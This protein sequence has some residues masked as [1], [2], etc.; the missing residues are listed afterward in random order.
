MKLNVHIFFCTLCVLLNFGPVPPSF[1][2]APVELRWLQE[3]RPDNPVGISWGVP[4]P[5]GKVQKG[6]HFILETKNGT[7]LPLQNWPLAYWPDGSLKWSGFATVAPVNNSLL[8]LKISEKSTAFENEVHLIENTRK[9][10]ISTGTLDCIIPK[11]GT[12]LLDSLRI[13]GR[14]IAGKGSI[15]CIVQD[16]LDEN[17][18]TLQRKLYNSI[19]N[20]VTVEQK[21]PV[22][23]MVRIRGRLKSEA[24]DHSWLPLDIRMYFYA[25]SNAVRL[26]NTM[27]YDGDEH[28][29]FI[30][31]L[32]WTFSIPMREQLH[33]RHVRFA[34]ENR[35]MWAEP[36]RPLTGRRVISIDDK[37]VFPDQVKGKAI[38]NTKQFT[39]DKQALIKDLPAW[40]DYRLIQNTANGFLVQKRT[41][42]QSAWITAHAGKRSA[43]YA[44]AGDTGGGLGIGIKDFWQ[45]YP[46]AME[47][48]H[49]TSDHAHLKAWLW[50]P[51]AEAMDMRHYDTIPHGLEAT[52][53]DVQKGL[54][55][56][57]GIARTSELTLFAHSETPPTETLSRQAEIG[58][59][60]PLLTISPEYLHSTGVFGIWS[61]PDRSSPGKAWIEN[62]LNQAIRFYQKEIDQRNWYGFWDYGDVMHSYDPVRHTWR[63]DIGGF[64]WD[65]TELASEFWLWYNYIRTGRKDIFRMAE[66]MTRHTSEVDV[67]HIGKLAGLGSRHNV[68]HWG[69]GSKEVR[70]SQA[71][72]RR[73][74]YYL[75]TDERTGDI[76]QEVAEK[77]DRAMTELDPLRLIYPKTEYPTHARIGPDWLA[78]AG[79]WMTAWERT[80]DNKW[81]N[82]ITSGI[83]SLAKMPYGFFSGELGA[84]GY[85]PATNQMHMLN[86]KIGHSHLSALMGGPEVAF[87]LTELLDNKDWDVLWQQ[88]CTLWGA[89]EKEVQKALGKTVKVGHTGIWYARLPAY[90]Y[91]ITRKQ[92]F[93]TRAWDWFLNEKSAK[94]FDSRVA[95]GVHIP[96]PIE[97]TPG[98]STNEAAQWSLNAIQLLELAGDKIPEEHPLWTPA[99]KE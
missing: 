96:K 55:T 78:L 51:Y 72:S 67:Y 6:Q 8:K 66:A 18:T 56:P 70:E 9:I 3:H 63:Y 58:S 69:C 11:T 32:A 28:K 64:A 46:A 88:Y 60:P 59:D 48:S 53:E 44:F 90:M 99:T 2:Q 1:A 89:S 76:M 52:Y 68:R 21:G 85:D 84:F 98:I 26:V 23:A 4:W 34:G 40:S 17:Q 33:N 77:A 79:N 71:A 35:G 74:Y 75:T 94:L 50:S 42:P 92:E 7:S 41:N 91:H 14:M 95:D 93:A 82:K 54:S 31:G 57:Y 47:I 62:R 12:I 15:E 16:G 24:G 65:N 80:G 10:R 13:N 29:D 5:E 27:T 61:L 43:G 83:H 87:E 38:A 25:G 45:S 49:T 39:G 36:V 19:I 73:F 86:N 37:D 97:E 20:E 22:K 30:K 81:R